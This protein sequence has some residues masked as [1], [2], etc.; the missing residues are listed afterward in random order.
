M[1][2][3][4]LIP[5]I[6]KKRRWQ[7][8]GLF[9]LM[10]LGAVAEL[11]TLGAVLPFIATLSN[12]EKV[13][14]YPT[15]AK[16]L[17]LFGFEKTSDLTLTLTLLFCW[18][19]IFAAAIRVTLS[20]ASNRFVYGLGHDLGVRVYDRIL[21]QPY[22]YHVKQ[23]TSEYIAALNK[24][25]VVVNAVLLP[26][27]QAVIATIIAV[28][29]ASAVFVIQPLLFIAIASGF[30]CVYLIISLAIKGKLRSN[31]RIFARMSVTRIQCLQEGVGGIRDVILDDS[32][33][34]FIADFQIEDAQMRRA[35]ASNNFLNT[36]PRFLVEGLGV[37]TIVTIAF[38]LS[39]R[40]GGLT[41]SLPTLGV[42][43]LGA[44]R[45]LPLLQT[46]YTSWSKFTGNSRVILD[47]L[48]FLELPESSFRKKNSQTMENVKFDTAIAINNLSFTYGGTQEEVLH[49]ISLKIPRGAI[50]GFRGETGCGKSTLIDLIMGLLSPTSGFIEIDGV[51]LTDAN[52]G[53][54]YKQIAHVPQGIYLADSTILENIA[55]GVPRDSIDLQR[56]NAAVET[57]I[58]SKFIGDLPEGLESAVGERGVRLSGGQRQRIGIAR[59]IYK[60]ASV[61][62]LDEATSALDGE[63]EQKL[64]EKIN[65]FDD[66]L[67]ILMIA[68][69]LETLANCDFQVEMKNGQISKV[70]SGMKG[71]NSSDGSSFCH[72]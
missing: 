8:L 7:F 18:I 11:C 58:L 37:L 34:Q 68:H 21:D 64:M 57:A 20:F 41:E 14:D 50:V 3:R 26:I 49:Q 33:D 35:Q 23:N 71:P 1:M 5:H 61:L 67:T 45:L 2:I 59:A 9:F 4:G 15:V 30:G 27:V 32:Q 16:T 29:I 51:T 55:F 25:T 42:I 47:V 39:K 56:V 6:S 66:K 40:E 31:S 36:L 62:V 24:V 72:S 48:E 52:R 60:N 63:T 69:R 28:T 53:G 44:Q 10:L 19:V 17:E 38:F 12:P 46:I 65:Q 54:W 13:F 70:T 43:V 22:S